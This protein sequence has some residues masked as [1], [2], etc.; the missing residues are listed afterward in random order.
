MS[1]MAVQTLADR[2]KAAFPDAVRDVV[3]FRGQATVTVGK[4][5]I[6]DLLRFLK[7]EPECAFNLLA[8]LCGLDRGPAHEPRFGV[9][10]NL[11]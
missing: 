3:I 7:E 6:L 4:T 9:V 1:G 2:L 5:S 8:D 11:Y 10:Y